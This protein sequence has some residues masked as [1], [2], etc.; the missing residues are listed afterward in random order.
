MSAVKDI[1]QR[2]VTR[3]GGV[4]RVET[5]VDSRTGDVVKYAL[6]YVNHSIHGGDNGRVLG[7][8]SS[9]MYPGFSTAHHTHWFG[10][11]AENRKFVSFAETLDRFQRLLGRLKRHHGK[12]Y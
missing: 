11:V 5:W 6:A 2:S 7:F 4:I 9:H 3:G 8:D 12:G 10:S 1:D